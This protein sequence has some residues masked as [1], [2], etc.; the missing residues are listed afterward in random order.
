[1]LPIPRYDAS[2]LSS[3]HPC[4]VELL[5]TAGGQGDVLDN[6]ALAGLQMVAV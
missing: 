3:D 1:M 2:I 4:A 5:D 6:S